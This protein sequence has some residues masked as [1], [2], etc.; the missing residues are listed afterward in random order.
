M[1]DAR[2]GLTSVHHE[3][4]DLFALQQVR[5]RGDLLHRVSYEAMDDVLEGMIKNG[6]A[7]LTTTRLGGA[8]APGQGPGQ[9]PRQR[10]C[11]HRY[12]AHGVRT[13]Q[14][15]FRQPNPRPK[16][17]HCTLINDDLLRRIK[18]AGAVPAPFTSY[19]YSLVSG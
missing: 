2:Y 1:T 12:G 8:G 7:N 5:A 15:L 19:A 6:I 11:H 17:T 13:G 10:G 14:R 3:G 9:L 4:G 18:A 16:I